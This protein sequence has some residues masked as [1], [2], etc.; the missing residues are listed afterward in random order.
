MM[1]A[2]KMAEVVRKIVLMKVSTTTM[3]MVSLMLSLTSK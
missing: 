2:K 1:I 3:T